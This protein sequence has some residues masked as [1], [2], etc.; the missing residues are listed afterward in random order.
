MRLPC[1]TRS[2]RRIDR[3]Q[4]DGINGILE[5]ASTRIWN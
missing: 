2:R 3:R 1:C 4:G 5:L